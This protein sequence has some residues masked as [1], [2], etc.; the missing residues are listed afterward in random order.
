MYCARLQVDPEQLGIPERA[1]AAAAA[2][3]GGGAVGQGAEELR[4]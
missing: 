3:K 1:A 2:D 4:V